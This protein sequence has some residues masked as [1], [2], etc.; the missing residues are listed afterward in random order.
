M[1]AGAL[2][3][4]LDFTAIG[5]LASTLLRGATRATAVVIAV[6]VAPIAL[7]SM[8]VAR[9]TPLPE[10]IVRITTFHLPPL[11]QAG[12]WWLIVPQLVHA[13]LMLALAAALAGPRLVRRP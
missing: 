5:V 6:V 4:A 9:G 3:L 10:S 1:L 7:S 11:W 2:A 8:F 13:A 12:S